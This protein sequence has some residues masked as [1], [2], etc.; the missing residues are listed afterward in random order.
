MYTY[1]NY[2][3]KRAVI[4]TSE[5]YKSI[6][7]Y[8][9]VTGFPC[10]LCY[11]RHRQYTESCLSIALVEYSNQSFHSKTFT[12]NR[13]SRYSWVYTVCPECLCLCTCLY[14][15]CACSLAMLCFILWCRRLPRVTSRSLLRARARLREVWWQ[16]SG[17]SAVYSLAWL[18]LRLPLKPQQWWRQRQRRRRLFAVRERAVAHTEYFS[19]LCVYVVSESV[20]AGSHDFCTH[21]HTNRHKIYT[22]TPCIFSAERTTNADCRC[23]STLI[24]VTNLFRSVHGV[25]SSPAL[26]CVY[27]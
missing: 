23:V 10:F 11:W 8:R 26:L 4:P 17:A 18:P 1:R 7:L 14:L 12:R 19:V 6:S 9:S 24:P 5:I 22:N 16:T 13:L 21:T 2:R 27:V 20:H 3:Y 15:F 25:H